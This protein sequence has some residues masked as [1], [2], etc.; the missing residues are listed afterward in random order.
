M[1]L[2]RIPRFSDDGSGDED[3]QAASES[4]PSTTVSELPQFQSV[5]QAA[6]E[7]T[8]SIEIEPNN[9]VLL[10]LS[11]TVGPPAGI[12]RWWFTFEA[13]Q[14]GR[15]LWK[16]RSRERSPASATRHFVERQERVVRHFSQSRYT[17]RGAVD[18]I[19]T[20]YAVIDATGPPRLSVTMTCNPK[21]CCFDK[22]AAAR[23]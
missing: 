10:P 5:V 2:R 3:A 19:S 14:N 22:S 23:V 13:M 16:I 4:T 12:A 17:R 18:I 11:S 1:A 9:D 15:R 7:S 8:H 20:M 6:A 21:G